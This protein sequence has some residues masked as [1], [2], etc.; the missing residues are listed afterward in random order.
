MIEQNTTQV[1]EDTA[2]TLDLARTHLENLPPLKLLEALENDPR[3]PEIIAALPP[4][5]IAAFLTSLAKTRPDLFL[6]SLEQ[7]ISRCSN[8]E[9]TVAFADVD[10]GD[11]LTAIEDREYIVYFAEKTPPAPAMA[12]LTE[13]A[14]KQALADYIDRA[15]WQQSDAADQNAD[16]EPPPEELDSEE[17]AK[18]SSQKRQE[19]A[20]HIPAMFVVAAHLSG[21]P[22]Y[23]T[24]VLIETP[25][26][27]RLKGIE[28]DGTFTYQYGSEAA[29][30]SGSLIAR[31]SPAAQS[32]QDLQLLIA[33]DVSQWPSC[34]I[35]DRAS[36]GRE[37][38]TAE[39]VDYLGDEEN[40]EEVLAMMATLANELQ[41]RRGGAIAR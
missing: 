15:W 19:A 9:V 34:A 28:A 13:S 16:L 24:E 33:R 14:Y 23:D 38:R 10:P 41:P 17:Y 26:G 4:D 37:D 20:A 35:E 32:K 22:Y 7:L 30:H 1:F 2:E 6:E 3:R 39:V 25:K 8:N 31:D 18:W 12:I 11:L 36:S 21:R 5:A 40:Q 29:D 27:A